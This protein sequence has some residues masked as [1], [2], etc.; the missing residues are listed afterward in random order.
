MPS[1]GFYRSGRSPAVPAR[2]PGA[3]QGPLSARPRPPHL[4]SLAFRSPPARTT[5]APLGAAPLQS[6]LRLSGPAQQPAA[7]REN[8][9]TGAGE[10]GRGHRAAEPPVAASWAAAAKKPGG[11]LLACR[12]LGPV[13]FPA[14]PAPPLPPPALGTCRCSG[15]SWAVGPEVPGVPVIT[16]GGFHGFGC[17]AQA[18][19]LLS[20]A[21]AGGGSPG[22]GLPGGREREGEVDG[23]DQ[24]VGGSMAA[25]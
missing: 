25:A 19:D 3:A 15:R 11:R 6:R 4:S 9:Q 17:P 24:P 22:L 13:C 23:R 7:A 10:R 8:T 14:R 20:G 21:P 5:P 16:C 18:A 1:E 12:A 2:R